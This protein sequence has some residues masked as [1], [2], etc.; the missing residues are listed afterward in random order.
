MRIRLDGG[1]DA[2]LPKATL[3]VVIYLPL[4]PQ[5]LECSIAFILIVGNE[6]AN[7]V[8]EA[9]FEVPSILCVVCPSIDS[10]TV[11]FI[12]GEV[13]QKPLT[14]CEANLPMSLFKAQIEVT[15]ICIL[16]CILD[17]ESVGQVSCPLTSVSEIRLIYR[18]LKL[19]HSTSPYPLN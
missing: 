19:F 1:Y 7:S 14:A 4:T 16:V 12:V 15:F 8:K 13:T 17:S 5:S 18:F 6:A 9:I 2:R 11:E 3:T 10:E